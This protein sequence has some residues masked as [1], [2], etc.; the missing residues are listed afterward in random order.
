MEEA[1]EEIGSLFK[2]W[3]NDIAPNNI[4]MFRLWCFGKSGLDCQWKNRKAPTVIYEQAFVAKTGVA[5]SGAFFSNI[6]GQV[7]ADQFRLP[8]GAA[9][10][11]ISWYGIYCNTDLQ[12][13]VKSINFLI[14]FYRDH[15]GLPGE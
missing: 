10:A 6:G 7:A 3:D 2:A 4:N 12:S 8:E 14:S 5:G 1:N 15:K 9:I 13:N 11:G